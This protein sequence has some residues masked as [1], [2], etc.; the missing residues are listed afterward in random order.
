MR[1]VIFITKEEPERVLPERKRNRRFGLSRTEMQ[2]I[3]IIGNRLVQRRERSV[4]HEMM[5]AGIGFL[6]AGRCHPHVDEAEAYGRPTRHV[7]SI[8]RIDE[9]NLGVRRGRMST[10]SFRRRGSVD[11]P[12]PDTLGHHRR[13]MRD[14]SAVSQ[15]KLKGMLPRGQ[16]H[17]GL[18]LAG[19]KMQ[20]I[21]V[22]RN[23]LI[24]R[25]QLGIDYQM[26]VSGILPIGPRRCYPHAAKPKTNSRL[27]R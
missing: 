14:V 17:F 23:R 26:V 5:M 20:V 25:R 3:K 27:G 15:Q 24:Q 22:A 9:I 6:N 13:R 16:V 18:G 4:D 21:E 11:D 1:D 19:A 8:S 10:R 7:G 2:V 12:D